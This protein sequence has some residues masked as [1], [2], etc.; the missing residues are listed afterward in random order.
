MKLPAFSS[1]DSPP[2]QLDRAAD[3][4]SGRQEFESLRARQDHKQYQDHMAWRANDPPGHWTVPKCDDFSGTIV[5]R[6]T[7]NDV[8]IISKRSP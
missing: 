5:T 1:P 2:S 7:K 4:E 6:P 3:Y 8:S